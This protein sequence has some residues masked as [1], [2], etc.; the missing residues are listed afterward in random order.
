MSDFL[1][2]FSPIEGVLV[3]HL[4]AFGDTR[5]R[6]SETFRSEWFPQVS[7]ERLQCNRSDSVAG[8]LRGLHYHFEQVDYWTV[9]FGKVRVGLV[10]LRPHSPTYRSAATLDVDAEDRLGVFIPIGVAHGFYALSD[11]TLMYTVNNYYNGGR[12][13]FGVAWDDPALGLDWGISTPPL[14]SPRDQANPRLADIP[15]QQLPR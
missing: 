7:W 8:V 6:F 14:L 11:C 1:T 2:P 9:P 3:A 13:E 5:G 15:S 12:D 10:D 4:R